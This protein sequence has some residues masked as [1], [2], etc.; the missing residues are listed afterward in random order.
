MDIYMKLSS[1][2]DILLQLKESF[3]ETISKAKDDIFSI[4]KSVFPN[5][6]TNPKSILFVKCKKQQIKYYEKEINRITYS[7]E[8]Y[9]KELIPSTPSP[10]AHQPVPI[11]ITHNTI[12][13]PL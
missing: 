5:E 7:I 2:I 1:D 4:E 6:L 13:T 9:D 8:H 3:A 12:S 10:S 11:V